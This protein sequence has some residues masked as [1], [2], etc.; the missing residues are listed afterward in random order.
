[1]VGA[2]TDDVV[3][4]PGLSSF[5]LGLT[6]ASDVCCSL[7]VSSKELLHNNTRLTKRVLSRRQEM[8]G[9]FNLNYQCEA[10]MWKAN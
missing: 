3:A 2:A 6:G 4:A 7:V 8:W 10:V 5:E 1:M 9:P